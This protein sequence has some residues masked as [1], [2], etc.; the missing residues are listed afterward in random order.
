MVKREI[1]WVNVGGKKSLTFC[2]FLFTPKDTYTHT[3]RVVMALETGQWR[4][5]YVNPGFIGLVPQ[6]LMKI[7]PISPAVWVRLFVYLFFCFLG[8]HSW[9]MEGP[10]PGVQSELRL[11]LYATAAATSDQSRLCDLH[12]SSHQCRILNP[13]SEARDRT[14]NLMVPSRIHFCCATTGTPRFRLFKVSRSA[15][16]SL[17][18]PRV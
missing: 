10:R 3:K 2:T 16:G 13:L 14:R 18:I 4:L 1:V 8:L 5:C 6:T 17:K 9:H 11:P 7:S 12:H 15:M